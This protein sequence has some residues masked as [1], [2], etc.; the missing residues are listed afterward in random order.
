MATISIKNGPGITFNGN[1]LT[2]NAETSSNL[3]QKKSDGLYVPSLKGSNG[4][5][6]GSIAD[7][8]TI[9]ET[10]NGAR[11]Y[12]HVNVNYVQCIFSMCMYQ[13]TSRGTVESYAI[14][15]TI[16]T[17]D[18]IRKECNINSNNDWTTYFIKNHDLFMLRKSAHPTKVS[19]M[20][21]AMDDGNRYTGESCVAVFVVDECV[22]AD[23]YMSKLSMTCI[24]SSISSYV[25]G[26]TY[27]SSD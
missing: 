25:A 14:S 27:T 19:G 20:A 6:G 12:L 9:Y 8:I 11:K 2:V 7:G 26:Q 24:W 15:S 1:S 4:P 10:D 16:K 3:I 23:Y 17:I 21:Y 22:Q 5:D 18:D 13:V